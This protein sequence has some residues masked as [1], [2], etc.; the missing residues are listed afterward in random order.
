[1]M[2]HDELQNLFTELFKIS[3]ASGI[4]Q[5]IAI[6]N[7]F[8]ELWELHL[9]SQMFSNNFIHFKTHVQ[10]GIF[11]HLLDEH[12]KVFEN[13]SEEQKQKI[14]QFHSHLEQVHHQLWEPR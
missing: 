1:M 6:Q 13:Y 4:V 12:A 2:T 11:I 9:S 5:A 10:Y 14:K 7:Y 8:I 3:G